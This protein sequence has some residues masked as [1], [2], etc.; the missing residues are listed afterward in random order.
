MESIAQHCFSSEHPILHKINRHFLKRRL[1]GL[2]TKV[3]QIIQ[4]FRAICIVAQ[5]HYFDGDGPSDRTTH[6]QTG[7]RDWH[8]ENVFGI[9]DWQ[10]LLHFVKLNQWHFGA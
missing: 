2:Q 9:C 10:M 6:S 1:T 5:A 8:V 4:V 3:C 7:G